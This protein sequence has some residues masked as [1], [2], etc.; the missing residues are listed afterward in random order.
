MHVV[1]YLLK[2]SCQHYFEPGPEHGRPKK[3]SISESSE[4]LM[5]SGSMLHFFMRVPW[6]SYIMS[7]FLLLTSLWLTMGGG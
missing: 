7:L 5:C 3:C 4:G 2:R 6:S 1:F